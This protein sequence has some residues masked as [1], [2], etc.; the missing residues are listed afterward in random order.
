MIADAPKTFIQ[1]FHQQMGP[2]D[3][4]DIQIITR[5]LLQITATCKSVTEPGGL[6]PAGIGRGCDARPLKGCSR[7]EWHG[8]EELGVTIWLTSEKRTYWLT[9]PAHRHT[10]TNLYG[11]QHHTGLL[12]NVYMHY[13]FGSGCSKGKIT[14]LLVCLFYS[15]FYA[16]LSQKKLWVDAACLKQ[17]SPLTSVGSWKK[18]TDHSNERWA[19]NKAEKHI[20]KVYWP[21]RWFKYS[22][23]DTDELLLNISQLLYHKQHNKNRNLR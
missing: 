13:T 3:G 20:S 4:A 7:F 6:H 23:N 14:G 12:V 10:H 8:W 22:Y 2:F 15:H 16:I 5:L 21:S 18:K 1:A 9:R 17:G 19:P 11:G